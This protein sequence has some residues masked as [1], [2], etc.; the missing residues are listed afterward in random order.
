M[1]RSHDSWTLDLIDF[2][3]SEIRAGLCHCLYIILFIRVFNQA[4]FTCCWRRQPGVHIADL[5]WIESILNAQ[6]FHSK[7]DSS[8]LRKISFCVWHLSHRY[9][10]SS[11]FFSI[12]FQVAPWSS[13]GIGESTA[14]IDLI[15]LI[16]L[17]CLK[18]QLDYSSQLAFKR[19]AHRTPIRTTNESNTGFYLFGIGKLCHYITLI[20]PLYCILIVKDLNSGSPDEQT[21]EFRVDYHIRISQLFSFDFKIRVVTYHSLHEEEGGATAATRL[22]ERPPLLPPFFFVSPLKGQNSWKGSSQ[23]FPQCITLI[24]LKKEEIMFN[25]CFYWI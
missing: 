2:F 16:N 12:F 11:L 10:F 19:K 21:T 23:L 14:S 20:G 8:S 25:H 5:N 22:R 6:Y 1:I 18:G 4:T 17:E 9:R 13:S 3:F 7:F 24:Y 15:I